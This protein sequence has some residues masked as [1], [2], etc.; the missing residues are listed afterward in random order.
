MRFA[1]DCKTELEDIHGTKAEFDYS[2]MYYGLGIGAGYIIKAN[3]KID[4]DV[5]GKYA[6]TSIGSGE[7]DLATGAGEKYEFEGVMSNRIKAGCKGEYKIN[8]TIKPYVEIAYDYELSGEVNAKIEGMK[9]EAPSLNGGTII[10][11]IGASGKVGE[12]LMIDLSGK[13]FSG[14]REGVAGSLQVK[15]QF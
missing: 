10:G 15:W 14:A 4:I 2:A 13:L 8:E 7:S 5:Y 6:L 3:E 12:R 9:V 11:G 1:C